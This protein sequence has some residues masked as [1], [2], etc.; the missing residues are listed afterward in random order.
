MKKSKPKLQTMGNSY[1]FETIRRIL[2]EENSFLLEPRP[3]K[4][5]VQTIS[6]VKDN[7]M[8]DCDRCQTNHFDLK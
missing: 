6:D 4:V 2:G 7:K 5:E 1:D 3:V 8:P